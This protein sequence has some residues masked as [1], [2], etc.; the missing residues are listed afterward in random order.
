[1]LYYIS[2]YYYPLEAYL[3]SNE[4]KKVDPGRRRGG[5]KWKASY[6][7]VGSL[8]QDILCDVIYNIYYIFFQ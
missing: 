3:L 8:N 1:L 2:F 4:R 7:R 6:S 5:R